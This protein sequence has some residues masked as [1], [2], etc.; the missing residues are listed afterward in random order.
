[1]IEIDIA[2]NGMAKNIAVYALSVMIYQDMWHEL[3]DEAP[4]NEDEKLKIVKQVHKKFMSVL[5]DAIPQA[6]A[7]A[8]NEKRNGGTGPNK[9]AKM[10]FIEPSDADGGYFISE[11]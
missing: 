11:N 9:P 7:C 8:V 4:K 10:T 2:K 5:M 6:I 3:P 1:M